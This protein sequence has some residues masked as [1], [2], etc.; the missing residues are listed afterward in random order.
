[1]HMH[2]RI[3]IALAIMA[4]TATAATAQ[5][6]KKYGSEAGWDIFIKENMGPGCLS[7]RNQRRGAGGDGH[8]TR[9]EKKGLHSSVYKKDAAVCRRGKGLGDIRR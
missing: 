8:Q 6:V 2:A 5:A 9:P 3:G 4:L 7:Q 1:M